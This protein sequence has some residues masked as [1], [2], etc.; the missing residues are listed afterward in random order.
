MTGSSIDGAL[1][2]D[3]TD[4]A[5]DTHWLNA[6]M[7]AYTTVGVFALAA[8][9]A[10]AWWNARGASTAAMGRLA[11]GGV[12]IVAAVAVN[13]GLKSAFTELRPCRSIAHSFTV[14]ACPGPTDY[15]FPSNHSTIAAAIAAA[16]FLVNKRLGIV[17]AVLA[18]IEGFSRVY[19]GVHYPHDVAAGLIVGAGVTV[20]VAF[21]VRPLVTSL[22][23]RLVLTGLRPL[24]AAGAVPVAGASIPVEDTGKAPAVART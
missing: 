5:R 20:A 16:L 15:S 6:P 17:A 24:L 9:L 10:V 18:L 23:G 12:G 4:F 22:V 1:Y 7:N 21:A 3:V 13:M 8:L 11:A 14:V 2:T 19:I